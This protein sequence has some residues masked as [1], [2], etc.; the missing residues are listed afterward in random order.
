MPA[1]VH[2]DPV[3]RAV[4]HCHLVSIA[5]DVIQKDVERVVAT[6]SS[7]SDSTQSSRVAQLPTDDSGVADTPIIVANG[8]PGTAPVDLHSTL[9]WACT[10]DQT[11]LWKI[12]HRPV[13]VEGFA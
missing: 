13:S 11:N 12:W 2:P 3:V 6:K 10:I 7:V 1:I 5:E 9:V 8:S 4:E